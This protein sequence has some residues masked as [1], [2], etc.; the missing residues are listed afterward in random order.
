MFFLP[1]FWL[2]ETGVIII[3]IVFIIA[4]GLHHQ[5]RWDWHS[6][7]LSVFFF[8]FGSARE[9]RRKEIISIAGHFGESLTVEQFMSVMIGDEW[10][11]ID[12]SL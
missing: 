11:F 10:L 7:F 6:F 5:R 2:F 4:R 8:F 12:G 9:R 3:T 1:I